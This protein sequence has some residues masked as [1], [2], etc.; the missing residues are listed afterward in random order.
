MET[1]N[2]KNVMGRVLNNVKN[3]GLY[4]AEKSC[5]GIMYG[6]QK[7]GELSANGAVCSRAARK[8]ISKEAAADELKVLV[9]ATDAKLA[10]LQGM[11]KKSNVNPVI[12]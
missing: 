1:K 7:V 6:A 4:M 10:K 12:A 8:D 5:F 2:V 11:F 9:D 3:G